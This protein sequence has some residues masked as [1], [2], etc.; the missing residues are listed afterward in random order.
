MSLKNNLGQ[1]ILKYRK[2][3][4]ITQEQ[5]ADLV[6]IDQKSI[7]KIETGYNYP[8]AE[9]ITAIAKALN[10]D[11]YKLFLFFEPDIS[12]MK[13]LIIDSLKDEKNI[14]YLY[15]CLVAGQK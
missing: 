8:T 14:L 7:S 6:G 13:Q 5:L 4:K 3:R 2:I 15:Q 12:K 10:V 1:N 9:N 11:I